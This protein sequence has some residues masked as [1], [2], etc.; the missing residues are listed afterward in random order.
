[1]S[2]CASAEA[3]K[4]SR[5][6]PPLFLNTVESF[7]KCILDPRSAISLDYIGDVGGYSLTVSFEGKIK[8]FA[9]LC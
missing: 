4:R 9:H 8:V 1:M 2:V 3:V 5:C 6:A 7:R